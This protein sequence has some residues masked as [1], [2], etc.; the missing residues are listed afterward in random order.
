M[1]ARLAIIDLTT[2]DQPFVEPG[3]A[4]LIG[5]AEIYNYIEL[6]AEFPETM[7]SSRRSRIA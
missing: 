5:N 1:Q 2:G 6:R 7:S 4:A 3:G